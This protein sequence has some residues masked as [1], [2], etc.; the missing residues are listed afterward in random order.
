VETR[1]LPLE[2]HVVLRREARRELSDAYLDRAARRLFFTA[3]PVQGDLD[4]FRVHHKTTVRPERL[5]FAGRSRQSVQA[6]VTAIWD[7]VPNP[8]LTGVLIHDFDGFLSLS[9]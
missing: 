8:S 9:E 1:P 6:A 3:P 5:T 2:R 7:T 4:W